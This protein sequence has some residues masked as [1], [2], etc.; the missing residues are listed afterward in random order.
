MYSIVLTLHSLIR[1]IV[2]IAAIAAV[3]VAFRGWFGRREWALLDNRLGLVFTISMDVQVLLGLILYIFLSPVVRAA[4]EDFGAAMTTTN[5]RYWAVEHVSLMILALILA[6]V[7]R[8]R[9][10]RAAE[11]LARHKSAA[12]FFGL[13]FLVLLLAIPWP[14]LPYGRPLL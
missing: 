12:I 13:A 1:W 10:R 2:V 4:F 7:G 9:V 3:V 14:F 8:A 5:V 6:H 11:D